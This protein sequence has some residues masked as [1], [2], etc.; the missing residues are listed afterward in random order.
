MS[1]ISKI[2][3]H[4]CREI[5]GMFFK[6][7]KCYEI[8]MNE[9]DVVVVENC[10]DLL[11]TR[12]FPTKGYPDEKRALTISYIQP[13]RWPDFAAKGTFIVS[14]SGISVTHTI[15]DEERVGKL[16]SRAGALQDN[17]IN[18]ALVSFQCDLAR[19]LEAYKETKE[20]K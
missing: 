11:L 16:W 8:M 10:R 18:E 1:E 4:R 3:E 9:P 7:Q 5:L 6:D 19:L 15:C 14:F 12:A 13:K 17:K 20:E 2:I